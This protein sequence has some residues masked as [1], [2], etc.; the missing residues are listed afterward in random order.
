MGFRSFGS[1][2]G[3]FQVRHLTCKDP[4]VRQRYT[5]LYIP[6]VQQHCL[7]IRS[8]NLQELITGSLDI[9]QVKEYEAISTLCSQ[10]IAYATQYC[11]KFKVGEVDWNPDLG[12]LRSD[13]LAWNLT[14]SKM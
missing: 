14:P 10:G 1:I 9:I 2:L 5:D 8:Y 13:I 4:R 6:F 7:D 12:I 3:Q 11:R